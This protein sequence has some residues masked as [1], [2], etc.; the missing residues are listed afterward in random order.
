LFLKLINQLHKLENSKKNIIAKI[1]I[2][3]IYKVFPILI[4]KLDPFTDG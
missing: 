1:S 3:M 2:N 4:K